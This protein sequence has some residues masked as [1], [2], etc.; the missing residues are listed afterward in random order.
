MGNYFWRLSSTGSISFRYHHPSSSVFMFFAL[1]LNHFN[2]VFLL[3]LS[4]TAVSSSL[5]L[6]M[7][8]ISLSFSL[9]SVVLTFSML[10]PPYWNKVLRQQTQKQQG[11]G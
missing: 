11:S 8:P 7:T 9:P 4:H 10:L 5:S 2:S 3:I 6:S 1:F